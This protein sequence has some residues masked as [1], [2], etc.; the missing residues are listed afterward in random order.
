[1][2]SELAAKAEIVISK[3]DKQSETVLPLSKAAFK[4]LEALLAMW[5]EGYSRRR[6]LVLL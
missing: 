2:P 5:V 4:C 1:M 6:E 3:L